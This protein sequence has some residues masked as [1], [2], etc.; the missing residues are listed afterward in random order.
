MTNEELE[1][2]ANG[3][4]KLAQE[5]GDL[6]ANRIRRDPSSLNDVTKGLSLVATAA[7]GTWCCLFPNGQ[8]VC[9]YDPSDCLASSGTPTASG[10][11]AASDESKHS[12]VHETL[13][14]LFQGGNR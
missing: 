9:P 7:S 6:L 4:R 2:Y 13:R 12:A 8:I 10:L 11:L 1:R 3:I 5:L 14:S